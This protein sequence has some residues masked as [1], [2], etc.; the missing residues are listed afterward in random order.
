MPSAAFASTVVLG[1]L[2][3]MKLHGRLLVAKP[4]LSLTK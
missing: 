1:L 4:L 3:L 2:T